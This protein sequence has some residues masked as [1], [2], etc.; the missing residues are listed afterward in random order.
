M[1]E[2]TLIAH[3]NEPREYHGLPDGVQEWFASGSV[4]GSTGGGTQNVDINF[5]PAAGREFQPYVSINH[6]GIRTTVA[7]AVGGAIVLANNGDWERYQTTPGIVYSI[8]MI[9]TADSI[10]F[11]GSVVDTVYLG[12]VQ[13]G[14]DGTLKIRMEE[15]NLMVMAVNVQGFIA[16]RPFVAKNDWRA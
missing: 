2:N 12:R 4:A 1:S 13:L 15:I 10:I 3:Q 11:S 16:D 6:I 5:N 8:P 14:T 7:A 9:R